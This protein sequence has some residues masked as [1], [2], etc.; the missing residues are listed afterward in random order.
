MPKAV[1][2]RARC[3]DCLRSLLCANKASPKFP[4][5]KRF[6]HLL[7]SVFGLTATKHA[8][9]GFTN[10]LGHLG[11][12]GRQ[13]TCHCDWAI[14]VVPQVVKPQWLG[15]LEYDLP[16]GGLAGSALCLKSWATRGLTTRLG[17]ISVAILTVP[18]TVRHN[19]DA[20][21]QTWDPL[22]QSRTSWSV[23]AEIWLARFPAPK[24]SD[25]YMKSLRR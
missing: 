25:K 19:Q 9:S 24:W 2:P 12:P 15:H 8:K 22:G 23:H 5:Q 21:P 3:Q 20:N 18:K 11:R 1:L 10:E 4:Y 17:Q 7:K 14:V 13:T 6:Y 16:Q